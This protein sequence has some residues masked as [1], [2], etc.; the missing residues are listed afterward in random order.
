[1]DLIGLI[2]AGIIAV[3][4]I[5]DL[6]PR[7]SDI[8]TLESRFDIW[9]G[10]F[11]GIAMYPI[12]GNG[13][14]TYGRLYPIYDWHK[15]PHAHN[16]YIDAI[17]SYGII[18]TVLLVGYYVYLG[19]E[20]MQVRKHKALFGMMVS[21]VLVYLIHGLLDCTLNALWTGMLFFVVLNTGAMYRKE[22]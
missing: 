4:L 1:M 19:K 22:N 13:P 11:Q 3:L 10:A 8:S 20:M 16:I 21:F 12:F 7:L 6:I 5:P 17:S 18:G 15:A 14:Q 9:Y 2:L